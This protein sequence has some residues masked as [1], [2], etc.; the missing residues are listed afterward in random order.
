MNAHRFHFTRQS[1]FRI[2]FFTLICLFLQTGLLLPQVSV[3]QDYMKWGLPEGA[4]I[5]LGKGLMGGSD[6]A[7]AF[8]PDGEH[9]AV[10]SGVGIWIYD[11]DTA[12]ELKLLIEEA[13]LIRSVAYSPDGT[14]LAAGTGN[15][16]VQLW[17]LETEQHLSIP[18]RPGPSGNVDALAFSPNGK[19]LAVGIDGKIE[20]WDVETKRHIAT[21]HAHGDAV[22]SLVFSPD[23]KMLASGAP[24]G[25]TLLWNVSELIDN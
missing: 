25:T 16:R 11:V 6:R 10:A 17:N 7:I 21:R 5:R 15:G 13:T 14:V 3:A 8:S 24:D 2:Y 9:L 4:I 18:P 12:R 23:G 1:K 20:L 19:T 22:T